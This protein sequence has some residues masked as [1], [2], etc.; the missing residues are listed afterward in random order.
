MRIIKL[1]PEDIS[2][3]DRRSVD[4]YFE[5]RLPNRI[6]EGQFFIPKGRVAKGGGF[7]E[8]ELL[9]FAYRTEIVFIA[10]A[11]SDL[12]T[13]N[14][15]EKSTYPSYF[16]VDCS[17][18]E[19]GRGSLAELEEALRGKNALR[20]NLVKAQDWPSLDDSPEIEK[21]WNQFK[22]SSKM[23]QW[24]SHYIGECPVYK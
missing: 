12:I 2:F 4:M 7:K 23:P 8:G 16:C 17:T 11:K 5:Q 21:I 24:E 18:I 15:V 1:S 10:K 6:P 9:I 13:N 20:K 22:Q 19:K 14:G 3:P